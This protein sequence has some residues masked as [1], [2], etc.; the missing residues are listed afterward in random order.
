MDEL[1][2]VPEKIKQVLNEFDYVLIEVSD[3][4]L[5]LADEYIQENVVGATSRGDCVHIATATI[6]N[7][8]ILVSWNF[9]HIVNV[10]RI[11]GYNSINIKR[12]YKQL[13]IRS[14][15]EVILYELE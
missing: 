5:E 11:K 7:V 14:P 8:D 13:D 6:Y 3:E 12:G 4:S 10:Q 1:A 15:K 9:K 2:N